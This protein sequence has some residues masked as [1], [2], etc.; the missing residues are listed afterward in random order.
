MKEELTPDTDDE[1]D[2]EN[3]DDTPV[4]SGAEKL[5]VD[6]REGNDDEDIDVKLLKL[7][8]AVPDPEK[9]TPGIDK[10]VGLEAV[11]NLEEDMLGTSKGIVLTAVP[12]PEKDI[13][14]VDVE[15]VE[16]I[17]V[18]A[19]GKEIPEE[20]RVMD[21]LNA[22]PDPEKGIP[23]VGVDEEDDGLTVIPDPEEEYDG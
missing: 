9:D 15:K 4:P 5:G 13:P 23:D 19:P 8:T 11:L 6:E 10:D 2:D 20:L 7:L 16:P 14:R 18:P 12:D 3:A 22:V 17:P 1:V 21:E